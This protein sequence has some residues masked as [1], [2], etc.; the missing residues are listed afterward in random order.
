MLT[1][2]KIEQGIDAAEAPRTALIEV[3]GIEQVKEQVRDMRAGDVME[4][5]WQDLRYGAR[6]LWKKPGFTL[7]AVLTLS[8]EYGL[9]RAPTPT[10]YANAFQRP[11]SN[12]LAMVMRAQGDP[13]TLIPAMRQVAHSLNPEM[14]TTFRTLMEVYSSSLD[15][16]RRLIRS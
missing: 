3:G 10:V 4:I 5:L 2:E 8:L 7:T 13:A 14:P 1:E 9:D 11:Q 16:R 6:M 12:S 15:A